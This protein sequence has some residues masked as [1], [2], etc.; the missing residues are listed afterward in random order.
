MRNA[1]TLAK[2]P[3]VVE[4]EAEKAEELVYLEPDALDAMTS[5]QRIRAIRTYIDQQYAILQTTYQPQELR[6][7]EPG[8]VAA[9][10][11]SLDNRLIRGL[12]FDHL[13]WPGGYQAINQ[14]EDYLDNFRHIVRVE[15]DRLKQ[16]PHLL[17]QLQENAARFQ[18][19]V[20]TPEPAQEASYAAEEEK[21][22]KEEVIDDLHEAIP[23]GVVTNNLAND[24]NQVADREITPPDSLTP[25]HD[26]ATGPNDGT[27]IR[28]E[29]LDHIS[30]SDIHARAVEPS[31][32]IADRLTDR[33]RVERNTIIDRGSRRVDHKYPVEV[34][35]GDDDQR[36]SLIADVRARLE[37]PL[38]RTIPIEASDPRYTR[39]LKQS[40]ALSEDM[41]LTSYA[42]NCSIVLP[43][44]LE[45][46]QANIG[47]SGFKK[48]DISQRTSIVSQELS[49]MPPY[50]LTLI[51]TDNNDEIQTCAYFLPEKRK[52]VL[53]SDETTD[54]VIVIHC[55][56]SVDWRNFVRLS[57]NELRLLQPDFVTFVEK[58]AEEETWHTEFNKALARPNVD[59]DAS[60][61]DSLSNRI[62][63]EKPPGAR[64][65]TDLLYGEAG[66]RVSPG[67]FVKEIDEALREVAAEFE[68]N[69]EDL[70]VYC[71]NSEG[72]TTKYYL[73]EV[74]RRYNKKIK[75][76]ELTRD[77]EYT[78]IMAIATALQARGLRSSLPT[79]TAEIKGKIKDRA[80]EI[81]T[82]PTLTSV[83][84]SSSS[85]QGR[86]GE[87]DA[88]RNDFAQ[89]LSDEIYQEHFIPP[90]F[91]DL[92]GATQQ[93]ITDFQRKGKTIIREPRVVAMNFE[94]EAKQI[95]QAN[96]DAQVPQELI[97]RKV[98]GKKGIHA[99]Y[100]PALI[101]EVGKNLEKFLTEEFV[102]A[103]SLKV[104]HKAD[105]QTIVNLAT[106]LGQ[107]GE[108]QEHRFLEAECTKSAKVIHHKLA[109]R[110]D[111]VF[112]PDVTGLIS[113]SEL[114]EISKTAAGYCARRLKKGEIPYQMKL[115][116]GGLGKYYWP[117][118]EALTFLNLK[119]RA[120]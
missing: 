25:I 9:A 87:S 52:A 75:A 36:V 88:A 117:R 62:R 74:C 10:K 81:E 2:K 38:V 95:E 100:F 41:D 6:A 19:R 18:E 63:R 69:P 66:G 24:E 84:K 118:Q 85:K 30:Y 31:L 23:T 56:T 21:V 92:D 14:I 68:V 72:K 8:I 99:F 90:D 107:L 82:D 17:A 45:R 34:K 40:L 76:N 78:S 112:D 33:A 103:N 114:D 55:G 47:S 111:K 94:Y 43:Q 51:E 13:K 102:T 54:E 83:V 71:L 89:I 70:V 98:F 116:K 93:L 59:D 11:H 86:L 16:Y 35:F 77:P 29:I 119:D 65:Q 73:A 120:A 46:V 91:K 15:I 26:R 96:I 79:L 32:V 106:K 113:S 110:I 39:Y 80:K 48:R 101:V 97:Q 44:Q 7:E 20:P 58:S 60:I 105:W 67:R 104:R 109:V 12:C 64:P 5:K 1:E 37:K 61:A 49:A 50:S 108:V 3:L 22:G 27:T 57:I 42:S 4:N 53:V 28:D 115:I